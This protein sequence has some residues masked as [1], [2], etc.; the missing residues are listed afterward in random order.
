MGA[1]PERDR[2]S[3]RALPMLWRVFAANA[4]VFAVAFALLAL[5]PVTIHASTRLDELVLLLA[6]LL[7]MLVA[8]LL[9]LR[10]TL[11]PLGRLAR[12]MGAIDLLR[13]GRRA[14]GFERAS[15]EVLGLAEAFNEM[16]RRLEDERR[17]SVRRTLLAQ[18]AER[19]EVA[20][21]L[22]DEIGQMLTTLLLQLDATTRR[23]PVSDRNELDAAR[24]SVRLALDELRRVSSR[25]R[26]AALEQLGLV[27]ALTE[28]TR[29]FA[30]ASRVRV[31][32]RFSGSLPELEP[33]TE[34]AIYRIVQES[35]TNVA[36]HAEAASVTVFLR[37]GARRIVVRVVD[38]GRGFY[39]DRIERGGL[40]GMRERA[41]LIGATLLVQPASPS[42][43]E[44]RLEVPTV[45]SRPVVAAVS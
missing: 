25:L 43:V 9:L 18:E 2:S 3:R 14:V 29:T 7:V 38:D 30:R 31:Q 10:Q 15:A 5:A 36:R 12:V 17:E 13:P 11:R 8:D 28:L 23:L 16:L 26:P 24:A 37:A 21:D 27:S 1:R 45:A 39:D 19:V 32:R 4:A 35:L 41:L 42:G 22:H 33:E 20:R 40:R 34:L 6:G 44:V